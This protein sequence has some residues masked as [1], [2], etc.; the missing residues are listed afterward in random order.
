[1][2]NKQPRAFV[3]KWAIICLVLL[4]TA[5]AYPDQDQDKLDNLRQEIK[6]LKHSLANAKTDKLRIEK[7]LQYAE[8]GI[9]KIS[10]LL[11]NIGDQLKQLHNQLKQLN[12]NKFRL[13]QDLSA[14]TEAISKQI[15]SSYRL[16]KQAYLK[17]LLNQKNPQKVARTLRYYDY[18]NQARLTQIQRWQKDLGALKNTRANISTKTQR[19]Q[20]LKAERQSEKKQ[21]ARL[22]IQRAQMLIAVNRKIRDNKQQ[23]T[24]LLK[25]ERELADLVKVIVSQNPAENVTQKPFMQLRG[26]LPWPIKGK[27]SARFGSSRNLG[28]LKWQGVFI[29]AASGQAVRA[30]SHGR[31]AYADWLRGFGLLVILDHGNGYMSLYGR[32]ESIYKEAGSWVEANEVIATVGASGGQQQS[33]LYFEVRRNGKPVNPE[34]WFK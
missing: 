23:L 26:Q 11:H 28:E 14:H 24:E 32:N 29:S 33:G 6:Q 1:M 31:V 21:L 13:I 22:Q 2:V 15:T 12:K 10:R 4:F 3:T 5:P 30:V 18:Y 25:S 34:K 8:V 17:L 9:S 20:L 27:I 7:Q 16:G 19:L